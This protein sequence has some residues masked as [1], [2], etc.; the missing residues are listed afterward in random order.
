MY[1]VNIRKLQRRARGHAGGPGRVRGGN[2]IRALKQAP[3]VTR[4]NPLRAAN[5]GAL[6]YA[7]AALFGGGLIRRGRG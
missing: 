3:P 4:P 5:A 1:T 2:S 6:A 7:L